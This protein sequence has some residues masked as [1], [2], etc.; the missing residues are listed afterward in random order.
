MAVIPIKAV[1]SNIAEA[2]L[3][4]KK[5]E[6]IPRS[7]G[8]TLLK[9]DDEKR[10]ALYVA[11]PAN[12]ADTAVAQ[13]GFR[14]FAPPHVV[15]KAAWHFMVKGARLGLWHKETTDQFEVV[16]SGIHRGPNWVQK[17]VDGSTR[18]IVEGDWLVA[19]RAKTDEAWEMIKTGKIGG[20]S[21]QGSARRRTPS[22]AEL[23]NLR[24]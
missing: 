22:S 13:D 7:E 12:K 23:A 5:G 4:A 10:V 11:Y 8:G 20:A 24:S 18:T 19:V 21:P 17:A 6:A 14:D 1:A 15:E 16:E 2:V 3:D 9:A